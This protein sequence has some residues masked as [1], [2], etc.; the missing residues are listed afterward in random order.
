M[1]PPTIPQDAQA[2]RVRLL[3]RLERRASRMDGA[4]GR[5][6][7]L[8]TL[9]RPLLTRLRTGEDPEVIRAELRRLGWR[10]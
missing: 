9:L 5:L 1:K 3:S 7:R 4:I 10:K 8:R 6:Q 2:Q